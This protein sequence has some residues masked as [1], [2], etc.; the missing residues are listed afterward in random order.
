[1]F[2]PKIL[3]LF[4]LTAV[5]FAVL[6]ATTTAQEVYEDSAGDIGTVVPQPRRTP[7]PNQR[8]NNTNRNNNN[9][10][11]QFVP[12]YSAINNPS[13]RSFDQTMRQ[14]KRLE[15]IASNLNSVLKLP[16]NVR[17]VLRDC[18][19]PNAFYHP[20][21]R[22]ITMCYEFMQLFYDIFIKMG[23]QP[24]QARQMMYGATVFFAYH[25]LG[26]ALIDVYDL[27][28]VGR[29]ED[30]VDQLSLAILMEDLSDEGTIAAL[31]GIAV[32]KKLSANETPTP[33][34]YADEHS[35]SSVRYYNIACWMYGRDTRK[36]ATFATQ[37]ILPQKR[38]V[39]CG[40]EYSKLSRAWN[41]LLNPW[42]ISD[43]SNLDKSKK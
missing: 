33:K 27:P 26:H 30:A 41:R 42:L 17:L 5:F 31:A 11:G 37:G 3:F 24:A 35:L 40:S 28:A 22:T 10:T 18:G 4:T 23:Y 1:M 9:L 43:L 13:F 8:N 7:A 2:K 25:E 38:A 36:F 16:T 21:T 34:S 20:G 29:E 12:V 14:E 32:F 39:R 6:P 19:Q 15:L